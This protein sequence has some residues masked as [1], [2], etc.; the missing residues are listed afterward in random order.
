MNQTFSLS[1]LDLSHLRHAWKEI[2]LERT[3]TAAP[4]TIAGQKYNNGVGTHATSSLTVQVDG[5]GK[6]FRSFVGVD[7]DSMPGTGGVVFQA[8]GSN[9]K[10]LFR[11]G[12][13]RKGMAAKKVDVSIEGLE[14]FSLDAITTDD[15]FMEDHADWAEAEIEMA[16]G[17][18]KTVEPKSFTYFD[19]SVHSGKT[20]DKEPKLTIAPFKTVLDGDIEDWVLLRFNSTWA[21]EYFPIVYLLDENGYRCEQRRGRCGSVVRPFWFLRNRKTN[22]GICLALA[23]MGNWTFEV[24]KKGEGIEVTVDTS[25]SGI[26]PFETIS[27]MPVPGVLSARFEGHWDYGCQPLIRFAQEHLVRDLGPNWPVIQYNTWYTDFDDLKVP[28]MLDSIKRAAAAG[29]E[30]YVVDAGWYGGTYNTTEWIEGLGDWTIHKKRLPNGIEEIEKATRDAGMKFGMWIEIECA[31]P[32]SP[33]AK[34]HP[35]WFMKDAKGEQIGKRDMLNFGKPEVIEWAKAQIDNLM[36]RYKLD[37]IKMDMNVDPYIDDSQ[38]PESPLIGHYKGLIGLWKYIRKTYPALIVENC[39]SGSLRQDYSAIA[40][41]DTHWTTDG[42]EH[43][44]SVTYLMGAT[45]SMPPALSSHWTCGARPNDPNL[46]EE[47]QFLL[48]MMGHFGVSGH[49]DNISEEATEQ[50]AKAVA[51]YKSIRPMLHHADVYHLSNTWEPKPQAA[52]YVDRKSGKSLLFAFQNGTADLEMK[53]RLPGLK[54]G[55]EYKIKQLGGTSPRVDTVSGGMKQDLSIR[56]R[57]LADCAVWL[58]EPKQ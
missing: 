31:H 39:S 57:Q 53:L 22:K 42:I 52:L 50:F 37:Y 20:I 56:F 6:R 33:V 40:H 48:R 23:Y 28:V 46:T 43:E 3:V 29:C 16:T 18:P 19:D 5:N 35:D 51:I 2:H 47:A 27:G 10:L 15:G 17:T 54:V 24:K 55:K 4:I 32:S 21:R 7:D 12:I 38:I 45:F 9:G 58:L 11:S 36:T 1:S 8:T 14:W 49:I 25:P 13:M 30:Q 41:T 26:K 44:D 34:E